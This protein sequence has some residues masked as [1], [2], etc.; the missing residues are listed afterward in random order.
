MSTD[1]NQN[2]SKRNWLQC[3]F[4]LQVT[5][6]SNG[7][8]FF[9]VTDCFHNYKDMSFTKSVGNE[10]IMPPSSGLV[11]REFL[12]INGNCDNLMRF[13][14]IFQNP[15]I[16]VIQSKMH[17]THRPAGFL[18]RKVNYK[19]AR[20]GAYIYHSKAYIVYL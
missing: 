5:F 20:V 17:A 13:C 1:H 8:F 2:L 19:G 3:N 14:Q 7:Q 12:F 10:F 4:A 16:L 11:A 9:K 18:Q 6:T 15:Y